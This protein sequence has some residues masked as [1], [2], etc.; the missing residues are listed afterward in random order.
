M[1]NQVQEICLIA[2]SE[3]LAQKAEAIISELGAPVA[4]YRASL[5]DAA[6]CA[7]QL[8]AQGMEVFIS[9]TGTQALLERE[10]N[11]TVVGIPTMLSDY[12]EIL[13]DA[14]N[15]GGPVAFSPMMG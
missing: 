11:A 8:M 1:E 2:P 3:R 14:R 9:R 15:A 12:M 13:E 7:R 4:V 5:E 10:L 6:Q